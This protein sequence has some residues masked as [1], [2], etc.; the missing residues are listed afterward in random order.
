MAERRNLISWQATIHMWWA[1]AWRL[2]FAV[3]IFDAIVDATLPLLLGPSAA[4]D[5]NIFII[6]PLFAF[7][8]WISL[9]AIRASLV[10]RYST[11]TLFVEDKATG[12]NLFAYSKKLKLTII[13]SVW[14]ARMWRIFLVP[15]AILV[16]TV[17][18]AVISHQSVLRAIDALNSRDGKLF[19]ALLMF[20][21]S[22]WATRESFA[23]RYRSFVFRTAPKTVPI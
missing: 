23:D 9:W 18:S 21:A 3:L 13:V 11:F 10:D 14:W 20:P 6:L 15:L 2:A 1:S 22:V 12:E 16:G 19:T 7:R 8:W 17:S 5:P 4:S